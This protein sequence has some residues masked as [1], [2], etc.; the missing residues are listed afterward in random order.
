MGDCQETPATQGGVSGMFVPDELEHLA[1][2]SKHLTPRVF[3]REPNLIIHS[4]EEQT[5]DV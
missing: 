4:R 1:L 5:L 2:I 3:A